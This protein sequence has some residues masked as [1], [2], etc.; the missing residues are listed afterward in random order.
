MKNTKHNCLFTPVQP[1]VSQHGGKA[2]YSEIFPDVK[3]QAFIYCYWQLKSNEPLD[4]PFSYRVVADGCIDLLF[5]LHHPENNF[6]AGFSTSFSEYSLGCSFN[7]MGVR[8]LPGAFPLL[9]NINASELTNRF[10]HLAPVDPSISAFIRNRFEEALSLQAIKV[11]FD[12]YFL[13]HLAKGNITVDK[14]LFE[15]IKLI[16]NRKGILH[17]E[18]E[19]DTG[20]SSRQLRRLFK[21]YIGDTAKTF[22]KVVRFQSLLS[23]KPS[24][25]SLRNN[26][27][28][29]DA[30]YY[31]QAHFIKEFKTFFGLTPSQVKD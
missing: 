22:S 10:E 4:K 7:Y 16:L 14:R 17:V 26:K 31:D 6:V 24:T 11:Q 15:A 5:E 2:V 20:L 3:L 23:A 12:Q 1:A 9:F 8:F 28:F 29:L 30:G 25:E 19:L 13:N 21:F 18:K 27:L